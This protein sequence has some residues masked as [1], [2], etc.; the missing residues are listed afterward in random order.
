MDEKEKRVIRDIET[1]S[2]NIRKKYRALKYGIREEDEK[3]TKSYKPILE[4]L[5]T[6]S[7][8]LLEKR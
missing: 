1:I 6:I 2:D 7:Q 3:L 8:A 4:P 5:K